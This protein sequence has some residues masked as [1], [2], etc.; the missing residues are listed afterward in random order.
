M[1]TPTRC[2]IF[3]DFA[4][5]LR[6]LLAT[7]NHILQYAGTNNMA[8]CGLCALDEGLTNI[9]DPEGGLVRRRDVIIDNGGK[10]DAD[11]VLGHTN[12][13]RHLDNLDLDINLYEVFRKWVDLDKTR[14]DSAVESTKL[15]D[16]TDITLCNRFIG[17]RADDTAW[18][19]AAE[20]DTGTESID[21][22]PVRIVDVL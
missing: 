6:D 13:L 17:I 14:V 1:D 9:G 22:T 2:D 21:W 16:E 15:G 19:G 18:N 7:L 3:N 11:V 4:N 10:V 20:A 5:G 12:L 8:E